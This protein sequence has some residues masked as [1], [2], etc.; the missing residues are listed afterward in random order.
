MGKNKVKIDG[1]MDLAQVIAYLEDIIGGLKAGT[2][3]VQLGQ[4]SVMLSPGN[5]V[6]CEIEV[7]QKKDKEKMTLELSWKKDESGTDVVRISTAGPKIE[8][9]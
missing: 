3:H 6:D 2:V 7:S 1:T 9:A 8:I 5:I 4:E